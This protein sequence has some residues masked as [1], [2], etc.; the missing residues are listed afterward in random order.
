MKAL[1]KMKEIQ[2][3][4]TWFWYA[5]KKCL[6]KFVILAYIGREDRITIYNSWNLTQY[7]VKSYK[8]SLSIVEL[9]SNHGQNSNKDY[10]NIGVKKRK[11]RSKIIE[12]WDP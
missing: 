5:K 3:C 2:S 11:T 7:I 6:L 8:V 1:K 10:V 4:L 9:N 12:I